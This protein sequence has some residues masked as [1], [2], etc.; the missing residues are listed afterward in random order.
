MAKSPQKDAV[1]AVVTSVLE[2][3]GVHFVPNSTDAREMIDKNIRA[4]IIDTLVTK[5]KNGDIPLTSKQPYIRDY[6]AGLV[7]NWLRKDQRLNGGVRHEVKKPGSR[8]GSQDPTIKNLRLV[9]S[10]LAP[11]SEAYI[12]TQQRIDQRL[13]EIKKST[14]PKIDKSAIPPELQKYLPEE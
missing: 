14:L 7:S 5:F 11:G 3:H 10:T 4:E 1:Y 6:V 2:K 9:Q 12:A 8:K 13:L